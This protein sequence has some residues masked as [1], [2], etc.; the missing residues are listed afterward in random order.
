M[1]KSNQIREYFSLKGYKLPQHGHN[2]NH[3]IYKFCKDIREKQ[4]NLIKEAKSNGIRFNLTLDEWSSSRKRRYLNVNL[5]FINNDGKRIYINLGMIFIKKTHCTAEYVHKLTVERIKAYGLVEDDVLVAVTDGASVMLKFGRLASFGSMRCYNHGLHLGVSDI[6]YQKKRTVATDNDDESDQ[7]EEEFEQDDDVSEVESY[8]DNESDD[9]S[10]G[11]LLEEES[12][13]IPDFGMSVTYVRQ[14]C[15]FFTKSIP[16]NNILQKEIKKSFKK[17][18]SLKLDLRIRWSS[19]YIMLNTFIKV[20]ECIQNALIILGAHD[21]YDEGL[22]KR[23]EE[24]HKVLLPIYEVTKRLGSADADI[25]KGDTIISLLFRKLEE[26]SEESCF[27]KD[28]LEALKIRVQERR[29]VKLASTIKYLHDKSSYNSRK[30]HLEYANKKEVKKF[31]I[32]I[33]NRMYPAAAELSEMSS[34]D[35]VEPV[36]DD[37]ETSINQAINKLTQ[38]PASKAKSG[39][40]QQELTEFEKTGVMS[41]RLKCIYSALLAIPTTL[42][43]VFS[44]K[45]IFPTLVF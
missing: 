36:S 42:Q 2:L 31:I 20:K 38:N 35:S 24:I 30:E 1:V 28:M 37:F 21:K 3:H 10:S 39:S 13:L 15:K 6:L 19:I 8:I 22:I 14:L 11:N 17:E 29:S 27:A 5:H 43:Q 34:S 9:D 45:E 40:I 25:L 26:I 12:E 32:E 18:I 7:G 23:A 4:I 41:S 44:P 16:R 33:S